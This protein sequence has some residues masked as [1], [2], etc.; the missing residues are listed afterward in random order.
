MSDNKKIEKYI[1]QRKLIKRS[2]YIYH[3]GIMSTYLYTIA[4]QAS[5]NA[6]PSAPATAPHTQ[7]T[8]QLMTK[9]ANQP[10]QQANS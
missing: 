6:C 5:N 10:I 8:Q 2:N 1:K 3:T 7:R 4:K 9:Q